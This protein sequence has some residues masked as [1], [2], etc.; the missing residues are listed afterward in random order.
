MH[1]EPS[2]F[3]FAEL[4]D[5][6]SLNDLHFDRLTDHGLLVNPAK[7]QGL[8]LTELILNG[9]TFVIA[10]QRAEENKAVRSLGGF[11]HLFCAPETVSLPSISISLSENLLRGKH[12]PAINQAYLKLG[13]IIGDKINAK[14]VAWMPAH[15]ISGYEFFT[16]IVNQYLADGLFPASIQ[17][18][19]SDDANGTYATSGLEYFAEQEA[20]LHVPDGFPDNEAINRLVEFAGEIATK[21]LIDSAIETDDISARDK[22]YIAP[23]EDLKLVHIRLRQEDIPV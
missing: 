18:A 15:K 17:I 12:L 14:A 13:K 22:V 21:G 6:F 23:S 19:I 3:I 10:H 11:E 8:E 7:Y 16:Y 4:D 9:M 20:E 1:P 2:L 5:E